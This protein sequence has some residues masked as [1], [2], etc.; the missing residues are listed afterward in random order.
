VCLFKLEVAMVSFVA[1]YRGRSLSEAE[2]VGVSVRRDLVAQAVDAMLTEQAGE[3]TDPVSAAL[4]TGQ[5]QALEL[6]RDELEGKA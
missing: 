5:T 6:V 1:L 2:L 4:S 3:S